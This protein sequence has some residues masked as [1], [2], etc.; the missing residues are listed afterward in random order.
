MTTMKSLGLATKLLERLLA[1]ALVCTVGAI[2]AGPAASQVDTGAALEAVRRYVCN[3]GF[4]EEISRPYPGGSFTVTIRKDGDL[5]HLWIEDFEIWPN[6]SHTSSYFL[7]FTKYGITAIAHSQSH[8][9]DIETKSPSQ[10]LKILK[11]KAFG[12]ET[13]VAQLVMP[14]NCTRSYDEDTPLKLRMLKAAERS[15]TRML[16]NDND[17]ANHFGGRRYPQK[18]TIVIAN[19]NVDDPSI[20]A[21]VPSTGEVFSMWV[22]NGRDPL[23]K[24]AFDRDEYLATYNRRRDTWR[25]LRPK[26]LKY[27]IVREIRLDE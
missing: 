8:N 26:I 4:P 3:R 12:G 5:A 6:V 7:V 11:N 24:T 25:A 18:L 21:L 10:H 19:F 17:D 15:M 14:T 27:G 23:G 16:T 22:Q 13:Q 20:L 1:V 2:S 9:M